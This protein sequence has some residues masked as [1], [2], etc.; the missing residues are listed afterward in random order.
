MLAGC[1]LGAGEGPACTAG[2]TGSTMVVMAS[3]GE[4]PGGLAVLVAVYPA[5]LPVRGP[6]HSSGARVSRLLAG[7]PAGLCGQGQA[8][9]GPPDRR[10]RRARRRRGRSPGG[11]GSRLYR[12]AVL[13]AGRLSVHRQPAQNKICTAIG[14]DARDGV[15]WPSRPR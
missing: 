13:W 15:S 3:G 8:Q 10:P 4:T 7:E 5:G 14:A 11:R 12:G 2:S 1:V 6:V 9:P